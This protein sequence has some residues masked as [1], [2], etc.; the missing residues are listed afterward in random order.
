MRQVS[1]VLARLE[2]LLDEPELATRIAA[3]EAA[4]PVG[5]RPR[6]LP[7]RSYLLGALLTQHAGRPA[8]LSRVREALCGLPD[9]DRRRLGVLAD[10]HG[11]AHEL[12]YRQTEHLAGLIKRVLFEHESHARAA[13]AL[14]ALLDALV[15]ASVAEPY[16]KASFALALDWTDVESFARPPPKDGVS[17]D[18]HA[19][20]G[21]RRGGGPGAKSELFFGYYLSLATMVREENGEEVPELVRQMTLGSCRHDPV[22]ILVEALRERAKKMPL[23]DVL[24]DSGYAHRVAE[25]FALPLRAAGASLVIDLHP[26]DRGP[27][28]T[29]AGAVL[30]NGNC[31]CPATP[32]A[33]F[34]LGPAPRAAS[35]EALTAHDQRSAELARYKLGRISTDD[36]DGYHRVVCPASAGKLRC[37]LRPSA[38]ALSYDH[39]TVLEPPEHPPRCCRQQS[40]TVP[41]SVNAKTRQKHDYPSKA[42]RRSYARRTAVERSNSRVKDP[43]TVDIAKGW[44]RLMG[45]VG[46]ALFLATAIA[47]RNLALVDAFEERQAENVRRRAVGLGPKTRRRRRRTLP[48]LTGATIPP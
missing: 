26:Q 16:T 30:A 47:V 5:V 17:A 29:F 6:Q 42:H 22:P 18:R 28:G 3:L 13:P 33:L 7:V 15:E 48:E 36:A 40:L 20:W 23:G 46:P 10:R 34:A 41:P 45:L 37:P 32:R 12:T 4:L 39:P 38:M 44:C 31:Y 21:H 24:C 35:T 43:A 2:A 25:H 1:G 11:L 14:S 19:S 9:E 27:Q 8:H